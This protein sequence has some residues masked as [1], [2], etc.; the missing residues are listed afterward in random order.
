M[1][2]ISSDSHESFMR[3]ADQLALMPETIAR[4][5]VDHTP[6]GDGYAAGAPGPATAHR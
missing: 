6:D 4:L 5:L 2:T 1:R 3:V